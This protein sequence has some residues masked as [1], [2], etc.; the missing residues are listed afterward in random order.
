MGG[1]GDTLGLPGPQFEVD[2]EP[3]G[4]GVARGGED[5]LLATLLGLGELS[6]DGGGWLG[7][8]G[9]WAEVAG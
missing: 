7:G 1:I 3:E 5:R 8:G 6:L 2:M 4:V 9:G